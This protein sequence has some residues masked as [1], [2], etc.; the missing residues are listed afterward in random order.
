MPRMAPLPMLRS[1]TKTDSAPAISNF[2]AQ[3]HIPRDSCVCFVAGLTTGIS[4]N[5]RFQAARYALPGPDFHR[6]IA[7][8]SLAHL[9]SAVTAQVWV[10]SD[11]EFPQQDFGLLHEG[12][13]EVPALLSSG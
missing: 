5:T 2:V 6:L 13:N 3:S 4:R 1:P 7:P 8:A 12:G 11:V 9:R 10:S